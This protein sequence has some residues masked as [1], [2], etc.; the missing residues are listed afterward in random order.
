MAKIE[1]LEY[2]QAGRFRRGRRGH[3]PTLIVL[4]WSAGFGD[5]D[6]IADYFVDPHTIVPVT[7]EKG[8]PVIDPQTGKPMVIKKPRYASYHLAI[9]RDG[10]ARQLVD[11]VDTAWHAGGLDWSGTGHINERSIGICLANRGPLHKDRAFQKAH[12]DRVYSGAHTKPGFKMWGAAFEAYT[13]PQI[14]TLKTLLD[15]L[16]KL[17]PT[18]AFVCGHEDLVQGKGD[19]GPALYEHAIDWAD[20]HLVRHAKDWASGDWIGLGAVDV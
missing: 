7:D 14:E 9:G 2:T 11:T 16:T 4:H 20:F 1:T 17:H 8:H 3:Q 6:E 5:A 10:V 15:L 13:D 18:L 12:P 19:P